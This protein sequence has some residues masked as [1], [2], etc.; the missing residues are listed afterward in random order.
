VGVTPA[1]EWDQR[2]KEWTWGLGRSEVSIGVLSVPLGWVSCI[3]T[4]RF[5]VRWGSGGDRSSAGWG[6]R[7]RGGRGR[8][9]P[10]RGVACLVGS[11]RQVAPGGREAG[12]ADVGFRLGRSRGMVCWASV[13]DSILVLG[14]PRSGK[15]QS[16]TI[17]TILDAP[18]AVI[19]TSSRPD[20]LAVT[21]SARSRRGRVVVFDPQG[22]AHA[23]TPNGIRTRAAALKGRCPRPLDDGGWTVQRTSPPTPRRGAGQLCF[24]AT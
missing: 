16:V 23:S 18:G 5:Q 3:W 14:P 4:Y 11:G 15:G 20:N 12:P 10:V 22:L 17:P 9:G 19:T 7:V 2:L 13:E 24:Q 8:V 1:V 6:R 21:F